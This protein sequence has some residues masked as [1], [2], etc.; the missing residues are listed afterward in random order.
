ML[1]DDDIPVVMVA[2]SMIAMHLGTIAMHLG[3]RAK[4]M[5]VAAL[6]H[7]GLSACI[8]GAAMAIAPSAAITYP[9][10]FMLSSSVERGLNIGFPGTFPWEPQENSERSFSNDQRAP[11]ER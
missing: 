4:V 5:I 1:D 11:L 9:N 8:D 6:D 2:P 7:D 10:F 3:A